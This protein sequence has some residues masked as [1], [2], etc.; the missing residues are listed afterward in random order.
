MNTA[1]RADA[2]ALDEKAWTRLDRP[3][4]YE[5]RTGTT[6]TRRPNPDDRHPG[7]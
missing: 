4:P 5:T 6:R 2:E 7:Q 3:A 1:L